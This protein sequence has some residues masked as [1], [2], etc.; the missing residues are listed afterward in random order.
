MAEDTTSQEEKVKNGF[1]Y[2]EKKETKTIKDILL[3]KNDDGS[4]NI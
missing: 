4:I 2:C 3:T 1:F